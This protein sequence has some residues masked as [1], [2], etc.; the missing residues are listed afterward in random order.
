MLWAYHSETLHFLPY[1]N[2][3]LKRELRELSVVLARRTPFESFSR[4]RILPQL[5]NR[6][7]RGISS[8][9]MFFLL[10]HLE[11]AIH[12]NGFQ[13]SP[14]E[15]SYALY[16]RYNSADQGVVEDVAQILPDAGLAPFLDHKYLAPCLQSLPKHV[17][18]P[19]QLLAPVD[20]YLL[21]KRPSEHHKPAPS[22]SWPLQVVVRRVGI[23]P[24]TRDRP[25]SCPWRRG[26]ATEI[27]G[28]QLF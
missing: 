20:F 9:N 3:N 7:R 27:L 18:L 12:Q 2:S 13:S 8:W 16:L 5:G 23:P 22:L 14:D 26:S 28:R 17:S 1:L 6:F 15:S 24:R 19:D 11:K 10:G 21:R 25:Q 4:L